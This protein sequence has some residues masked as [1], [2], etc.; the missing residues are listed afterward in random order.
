MQPYGVTRPWVNSLRPSNVIRHFSSWVIYKM[1]AISFKHRKFSMYSARGSID[2]DWG[3]QI[4][5]MLCFRYIV[6]IFTPWPFKLKGYCQCLPLSV[7]LSVCKL[8]LLCVITRHRF[9]L[10]SPNVHQTWILGYS[11]QVLKMEVIDLDLQVILA[12]WLRILRN[13]AYPR[14]NL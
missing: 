9:G 8:C 12:I 14:D 4:W 3:W 5:C 6:S 2:N 11:R 7:C 1:K 13:W 10:E